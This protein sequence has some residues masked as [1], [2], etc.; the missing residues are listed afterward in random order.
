MVP[1]N[2]KKLISKQALASVV[3]GTIAAI[4][5]DIAI[6]DAEGVILIGEKSQFYSNRYPVKVASEVIGWVVGAAQAASVAEML[7]YIASQEYEKRILA[8]D[9]LEKYEEINFLY[10][11]S[12][13]IASCL[14]VKEVTKLVLDEVR[15]LLEATSASV[16]LLNEEIGILEIVA[17]WG[18]EY[19]QKILMRSGEG[20]AG[21][22]LQEGKAEIV[23]DVQSDPR[24]IQQ[25]ENMIHSPIC[26]PLKIQSGMIGVI[27]I[28]ST[29]PVEYQDLKLFTALTSQAA[30]A[31]KNALS[32]ENKLREERIK[33]N[34]ERYLSPQVVQAAISEKGAISL[35]PTR[36]ISP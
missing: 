33:S 3:K 2:F 10:D 21:H 20:I 7:S 29:N 26:A 27:I 9:A 14:G 16:M 6:Q 4:D 15:K 5:G 30:A 17:A 28:S 23:N 24:Y 1:I 35:N 31:I 19:R 13:K 18:K 22:V 12:G 34:L 32:H 36:R 25:G 11:I 8:T